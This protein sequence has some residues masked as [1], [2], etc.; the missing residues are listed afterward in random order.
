[1]PLPSSFRAL[2]RVELARRCARNPRYSLRAFA[3][4]LRID[5][6]TLSQ[7]LRGRRKVTRAVILRL[8]RKLGLEKDA[9]AALASADAPAKPAGAQAG[10]GA[11]AARVAED[12]THHLLLALVA[13]GAVPPDTRRVARALDISADE[14]NVVIQRLTALGLLA[15][16][17]PGKWRDVAGIGSAAPDAFVRVVWQRAAEAIQKLDEP[18]PIP[19]ATR[20]EARMPDPVA[21]F[22]ILSQ[23][24]ERTAQF[25]GSVFGWSVDAAN[26]LGYRQLSTGDGGLGGG[27]WPA[28]PEVPPFV[29]LFVAVEDVAGS[30]ERARAAGARVLVAHQ[31]LPDG[32]EMAILAD[33]EGIAFGLM[34]RR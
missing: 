29:Q 22:Q 21:R 10:I 31:K 27:I 4:S 33:P 32:D 12:P 13:G 28:P 20:P 11:I 9:L 8:G 17:G 2:L 14:A 3:R 19:G 16:E 7:L 26:A 30:V 34:L 1:M 6:A 5:H 18:A 15:L 23:N 25:Y 24:P